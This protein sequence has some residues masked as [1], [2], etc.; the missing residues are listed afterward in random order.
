MKE[1]EKNRKKINKPYF[2]IL[3]TIFGEKL[4]LD[5]QNMQKKTGITICLSLCVIE[6]L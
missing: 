4:I 5:V 3:K 1:K 2:W 6:I